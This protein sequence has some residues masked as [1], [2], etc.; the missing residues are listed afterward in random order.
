MSVLKPWEMAR[1]SECGFIPSVVEH[2]PWCRFGAE[3]TTAIETALH[4]I[5][6]EC[7]KP[8][9][10]HRCFHRLHSVGDSHERALRNQRGPCTC[11]RWSWVDIPH[12]NGALVETWW[13]C[14]RRGQYV[15]PNGDRI[16]IS[17][18]IGDDAFADQ[19][20][21]AKAAPR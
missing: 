5:A 15:G 13:R 16:S 2:K 20:A 19:D 6:A 10:E 12:T 3:V 7:A 8:W 21:F 14:T 4:I 11:G 17:F 1:C 9:P 18:S